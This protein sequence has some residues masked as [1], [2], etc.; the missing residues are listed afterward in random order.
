M[1]FCLF[2]RNSYSNSQAHITF[3][4]H[5]HTGYHPLCNG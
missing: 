1:Y 4:T 5:E 3:L 2:Y